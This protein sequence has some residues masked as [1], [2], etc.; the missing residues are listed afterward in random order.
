MGENLQSLFGRRGGLA[1]AVFVAA[2]GAC[3]HADA[4]D[5]TSARQMARDSMGAVPTAI[6]TVA[7]NAP[8]ELVENS[9]AAMSRRQPGVLFTINDSGNEP[10]LFAI[11]TLGA[12]RGVWTVSGATN[13][14]W[15]SAAVAPCGRSAARGVAQSCVYIG[16]TGDNAGKHQ[17]RTIYRVVEPTASATRGAVRAE[18]LVYRYV[19]EP[20]DVEAMYVAPN[21]DIVLITK[22]P[23]RNAAGHGRPALIFRLAPAAWS[24][25]AVAVAT[26]VDSL[27][28]V[29][30]SLPLR[31]ITDA[32]L[33]PDARHLAVRTYTQVYIFATDAATGQVVH[34]AAPAVCNVTSL[35]EP[36]GEGLT[37]ADARGRLI[38]TSEGVHV[39]LQLANC[40]LPK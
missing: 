18:A 20:H 32:A 16:D 11:D 9:A 14:D 2:A 40:P 17:T 19:D 23:L 35:A 27:P 36:Q 22:R 15:E 1:T 10:L 24:N 28:I 29:P 34:S 5:R 6:H 37:W 13:V 33:S 3:S 25:H 7:L 21:G 8:P 12:S 4:S 31:L 26:L 38:F 30:G 39:P